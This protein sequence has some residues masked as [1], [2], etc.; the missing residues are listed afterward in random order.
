MMFILVNYDVLR[1][2]YKLFF[3]LVIFYF[4]MFIFDKKMLLCDCRNVQSVE[5]NYLIFYWENMFMT[6]I[7]IWKYLKII[8]E[9]YKQC[10]YEKNLRRVLVENSLDI[11][12]KKNPTKNNSMPILHIP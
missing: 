3:S 4:S 12:I 8:V 10:P 7:I 1:D 6:I 11:L 2:G 5:I 9:H